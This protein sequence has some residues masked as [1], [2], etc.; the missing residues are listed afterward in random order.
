[1]F[2]TV[3]VSLNQ[4]QSCEFADQLQ[5][6][7]ALAALFV[8][9]YERSGVLPTF[10]KNAPARL[11]KVN[12]LGSYEIKFQDQMRSCEDVLLIEQHHL[13]IVA[14][15]AGRERW[16][17]VMGISLPGDVSSAELWAYNYESSSKPEAESLTRVQLEDFPSTQDFHTLGIAYD[18][19][20][21]SLFVTNHAKAGPRI[22][23]FKLDIES[24]TATYIRT[25][26]HPLIHAPNA[27]S[28]INSHEFYVTN[29]H[30]ISMKQSKILSLV[31]TYLSIPLGTV[32]YVN[33]EDAQ[34]QAKVVARVAF[35]N[36]VEILNSSTVAVAST[37]RVAVCL[38]N[39][40]DKTTFELHSKI[41][42]PFL[43]DNLS[44]SGGKLLIAGHAHAP[45]LTKFTHTRHICND[46]EELRNA[47]T[48]MRE[49]CATGEATS[50]VSEWSEEEGLKHLYVDTKYPTSTTAC[51]DSARGVGI[52]SGLY[53]KG[54]LVW[55]EDR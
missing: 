8:P 40:P 10:Y 38:F 20:T 4:V 9:L 29:A 7:A 22:E 28:L 44:W 47:A 39:T 30:G 14:C 26:R 53:S 51:K 24:L 12:T 11:S 37:S 43:P 41:R 2:K 23:V 21:S 46:A 3:A 36:G 18:Q 34:P 16:N 13:A 27:I 55:R 5:S 48:D 1:M 35:A 50:W 17:T 42:L 31:E 6:V 32:V 33:L 54:L 45:S 19:E 25:I 49:Y 52:V 15:D